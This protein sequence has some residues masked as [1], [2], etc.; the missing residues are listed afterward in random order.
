[1]TQAAHERYGTPKSTLPR[2]LRMA[3]VAIV[4]VFVASAIGGLATGPNIP[5][6]Y[7]KIAKPWF[8]PP[9]WVFG[10]VWTLLYTMLAFAFWRILRMP[11][12]T[13][14]RKGAIGWFLTQ[15]VLN[16]AWSVVFFGMRSPEMALVVIAGLWLSI[17]A[18][19]VAF[20]R[21]DRLAGWIFAPYI[22][23]V[24]FAAALNVAIAWLN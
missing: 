21:L 1:M 7:D 5:T 6:W 17:V 15:I 13:P 2:S 11:A 4:V 22:A 19:M 14:G 24:S 9:N 8:T 23:W 12:D 20:M 10:P 3:L 18:N 16:A